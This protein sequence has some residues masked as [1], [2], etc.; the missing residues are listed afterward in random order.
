MGARLYDSMSSD[1]FPETIFQIAGFRLYFIVKFVIRHL[2]PSMKRRT[3]RIQFLCEQSLS[4]TLVCQSDSKFTEKKKKII[5]NPIC[6]KF[7]WFDSKSFIT[8][9]KNTFPWNHCPVSI[10]CNCQTRRFHGVCFRIVND[11]TNPSKKTLGIRIRTIQWLIRT[12]NFSDLIHEANS[13][14]IGPTILVYLVI[15]LLTPLLNLSKI[16]VHKILN[17][18]RH[19]PLTH[20]T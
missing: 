17:I 19:W 8:N 3:S 11:F 18:F 15:C 4:P 10:F 2:F 20:L 12:K 6:Q 13:I 1:K 9:H 14:S 5:G 7:C 16:N